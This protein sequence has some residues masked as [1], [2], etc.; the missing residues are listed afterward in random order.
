MQ[1][2]KR[3]IMRISI[4]GLGYVGC[5]SIGCLA[6]LGHS[7][8]GVDT[9]GTKVDL[10]NKGRPTIVEKN[11]SELILAGYKAK[12]IT[13]T[14]NYRKAVKE[15]EVTFLC[16]GTPNTEAGHLNMEYI[17]NASLQIA[18]GLKYKKEFHTIVIRSTVLPGTNS[19]VCSL[20]EAGSGKKRN[21]D[22]CVVSNPEFLREGNAVEDYFHPSLTV[23]ASDSPKGIDVAKE[24]YEKIDAPFEVV[25]IE[26][27]E[28]LKF[29]N[30]S[31]HALKITF[32]NEVGN[33]CKKLNID[34]VEL[35]KLFVADT[36]LNSSGAYLKPG[37]AFGGSCLPKDLRALNTI[38]HD[39]YLQL[40]II[41]NIENSNYIQKKHVFELI[42]NTK[43]RKIGIIGLSFKEGTD[44]LRESPIIDVIESLLGKGYNVKVYDENVNLSNI[45]G[46]NKSYIF[47]KLPHI[48]NLMTTD[49]SKLIKESEVVIVNARFKNI[50]E[51]LVSLKTDKHIIDLIYIPALRK[52]KNYQGINW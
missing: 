24:I 17:N 22:F 47:N 48:K 46:A 44:D 18:E 4:F 10:I 21:I 49:I 8:I 5:V 43:K 28:L 25:K 20:I 13:A 50:I 33:I 7:V 42:T 23:V 39:N 45:I 51:R 37:F 19:N 35:M 16:V 15:S 30:N 41:N 26:L 27:A 31:Y 52:L 38:A 14:K 1:N 40:P 2:N 9:N 34:A 29:I 32:A 36:K 6:D 3:S 11:I 12:K